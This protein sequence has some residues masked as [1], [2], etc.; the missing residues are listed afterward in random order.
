MQEN[1]RTHFLH[2]IPFFD[3]YFLFGGRKYIPPLILLI[4]ANAA[5]GFYEVSALFFLLLG[6]LRYKFYS[7][8]VQQEL[9]INAKQF[10]S[11]HG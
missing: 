10:S 9:Q 2:V 1:L 4:T 3:R 6:I 11:V 7:G 8:H 5:M